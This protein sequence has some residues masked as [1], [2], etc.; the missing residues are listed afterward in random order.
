M[1]EALHTLRDFRLIT[2]FG[3]PVEEIVEATRAGAEAANVMRSR[4]IRAKAAR[5]LNR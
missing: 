2:F 4:D 3:E 1:R 5:L